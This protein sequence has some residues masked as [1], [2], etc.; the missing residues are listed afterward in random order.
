M[1][2]L[3]D[4]DLQSHRQ[5]VLGP[6]VAKSNNSFTTFEHGPTGQ[7]LQ[8]IEVGQSCCIRIE[9]PV[10][11]QGLHRFSLSSIGQH[12][13]G[14]DT[15][16]NGIGHIGFQSRIGSGI[17]PNEIAAFGAQL[18]LVVQHGCHRSGVAHTPGHRSTSR[19]YAVIGGSWSDTKW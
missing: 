3:Q 11:P 10:P 17:A 16:T 6:A 7:G 5:S 8:T 9:R 19:A 18:I 15:G 14:L 1:L 4:L 13:L 2:W 12:G